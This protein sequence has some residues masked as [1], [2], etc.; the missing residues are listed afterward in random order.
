[1][2]NESAALAGEIRLRPRRELSG[3]SAAY[4]LG[5]CGAAVEADDEVRVYCPIGGKPCI[6]W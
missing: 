1:M 3:D 2:A 5:G 6:S 4:G